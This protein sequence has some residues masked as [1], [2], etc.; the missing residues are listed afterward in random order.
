MI[1]EPIQYTVVMFYNTRLTTVVNLTFNVWWPAS[2]K[3]VQPCMRP[4]VHE[5]CDW[6]GVL[7]DHSS[8]LHAAF[9]GLVEKCFGGNMSGFARVTVRCQ[10][11]SAVVNDKACGR[12]S[13]HVYPTDPQT[14]G[15]FKIFNIPSTKTITS[16][17]QNSKMLW[18]ISLFQ[19]LLKCLLD[20]LGS[21]FVHNYGTQN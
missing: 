11:R 2:S 20:G 13:L 14:I 7:L 6:I 3:R 17:S 8:G 15:S 10:R 9:T 21:N 4:D 1:V 16:G 5:P 18:S 19:E 12:A